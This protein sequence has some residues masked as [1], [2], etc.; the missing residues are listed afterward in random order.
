MYKTED[1]I[2]SYVSP[3][4]GFTDALDEPIEQKDIQKSF[5]QGFLEAARLMQ[6]LAFVR[7][8]IQYIYIFMV[9]Y[10][11]HFIMW[12]VQDWVQ[13]LTIDIFVNNFYHNYTRR[14]W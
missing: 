10:A 6:R 14:F 3:Q 2:F 9:V 13:R 5:D 7:G 8:Y 1:M 4:Q 12:C 11:G